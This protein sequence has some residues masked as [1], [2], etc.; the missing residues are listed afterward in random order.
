MAALVVSAPDRGRV[1]ARHVHA[2]LAAADECA[3]GQPRS[4]DEARLTCERAT[5]LEALVR[6]GGRRTLAA[7]DLGLSR[8]GL[9]KAMKRLG[10]ND[11]TREVGVA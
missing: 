9:T 3:P 10:L 8:Q 1:T 5:V 7:R 11:R 6:H 2:V 4:L